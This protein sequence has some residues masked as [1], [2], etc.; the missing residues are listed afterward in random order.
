M[1]KSWER[2]QVVKIRRKNKEIKKK[3]RKDVRREQ[4]F[5]ENY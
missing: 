1:I 4:S 2:K 3:E 5:H